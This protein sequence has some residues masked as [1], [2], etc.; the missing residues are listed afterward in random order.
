MCCRNIILSHLLRDSD[1]L[2]RKLRGIPLP[3]TCRFIKYDIKEF[4]MTGSH[5]LLI[6]ESAKLVPIDD[7][8]NY[9]MMAGAML[10]SQYICSNMLPNRVFRAVVGSGMGML[11]SSDIADATFYSMVEKPFILKTSTRR[12]YRILFYA[13][14][15][16]DGLIIMDAPNGVDHIREFL[17]RVSPLQALS[18]SLLTAFLDIVARC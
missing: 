9:R 5:G 14:F 18:R 1:D 8:S 2:V 10:S 3:D 12:D 11:P 4:Y 17:D 6:D 16:D 15:K 7:R 13:R